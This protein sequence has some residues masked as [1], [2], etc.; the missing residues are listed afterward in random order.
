LK[1]L[2]PMTSLP[3]GF[4]NYFWPS[5]GQSAKSEMN[6]ANLWVHREVSWGK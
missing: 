1:R 4:K 6:F 2:K 3:R 5:N